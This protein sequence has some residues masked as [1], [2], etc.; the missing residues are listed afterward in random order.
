MP[1]NRFANRSFKRS[2]P[3]RGWTG[4]F[5]ISTAIT[6]ASTKALIAS[7]TPSNSNID[8]TVLRTVGSLYIRS[9]QVVA[10]EVQQ[11]A[12]GM[13]VVTDAALAAGVAS[14]PGPIT[15][16]ADDGWFAWVPFSQQFLFSD[17]TGIQSKNMTEY[18][19][20]FKSKRKTEDG[21]SIALVMETTAGSNGLIGVVALRLLSMVRGT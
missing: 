4:I 10:S 12:F 5:D 6:A 7:F 11:G 8:E 16:I 15:D 14:I 17:A 2:S 13:I 9:D 3:N 19:F 20:D 18:K 1:R 21:Q